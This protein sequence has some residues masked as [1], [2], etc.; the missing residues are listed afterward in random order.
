MGLQAQGC[1]SLVGVQVPKVGAGPR[2]GPSPALTP[3][4]PILRVPAGLGGAG[5]PFHL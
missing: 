2:G 1:R 3:R 5:H 4:L